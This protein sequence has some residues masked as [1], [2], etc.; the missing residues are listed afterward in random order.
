MG[1][2]F[3]LPGRLSTWLIIS[4][5]V[6][7]NSNEPPTVDPGQFGPY[8]VGV[9]TIETTYEAAGGSRTL[10]IE[11]W[12]PAANS[13]ASLPSDEYDYV[14]L[15]PDDLK[16]VLEPYTTSSLNQPAHRDSPV[17]SGDG[18]P[19]IVFSHGFGGIRVQSIFLTNHLAS[20]GYVVVSPDH[21]GNTA[22]DFLREGGVDRVFESLIDRP[23]DIEHLIDLFTS[24]PDSSTGEWAAQIDPEAIGLSGHSLG[25]TTVLAVAARDLRVKA[26]VPMAP[27]ILGMLGL[28]EVPAQVESAVMVLAGEA[29][30][31]IPLEDDIAPGF[32]LFRPPKYLL[33]IQ[34]AGHFSFS[35]LCELDLTELP[36]EELGIGDLGNVTEDGCGP[37]NI[38]YERA[39]EIINTF[40]TAFFEVYLKGNFRYQ[41][42]LDPSEDTAIPEMSRFVGQAE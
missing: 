22:F 7:C 15:A 26:V 3:R 35:N 31:T 4:F 2:L 12:Y 41:R 27:S 19:L 29:D 42:Y 14:S 28:G 23:N 1:N 36:I 6:G 21:I 16:P 13:A 11:V 10:P 9:R 25:G 39:Y 18:F 24:A 5:V 34:Q 30:R 38:P 33:T 32:E 40:T 20:H 37:E 8:P 17:A